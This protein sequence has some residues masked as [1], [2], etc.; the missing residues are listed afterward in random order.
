MKFGHDLEL[1]D[2]QKT[3]ATGFETGFADTPVTPQE[4]EEEK[5]LYAE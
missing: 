2:I 1:I 5:E 4:Y 3:N